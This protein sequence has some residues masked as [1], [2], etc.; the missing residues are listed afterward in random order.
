MK[1]GGNRLPFWVPQLK[2]VIGFVSELNPNFA[3]IRRAPVE[4]GFSPKKFQRNVFLVFRNIRIMDSCIEIAFIVP[5]RPAL[6]QNSTSGVT[7]TIRKG[8][9]GLDCVGNANNVLTHYV[10]E[11]LECA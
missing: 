4:F 8:L 1:A 7:Q 10:A 2:G 5:I 3:R 6:G 11:C 9:P